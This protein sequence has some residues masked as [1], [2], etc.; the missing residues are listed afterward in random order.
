LRV[1][2]DPQDNT[3]DIE[4]DQPNGETSRI[5]LTAGRKGHY[6]VTI[7]DHRIDATLIVRDGKVIG[8]RYEA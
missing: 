3:V 5:V 2:V 6:A 4:I 1:H 8:R 7:N